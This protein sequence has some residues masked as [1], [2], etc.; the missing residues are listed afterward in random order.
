MNT[1]YLSLGA[2]LGNREQTLTQAIR[3]LEQQIGTLLRCSSF[4]YS[5]PWGFQSEHTFCNICASFLTDLTPDQL[6]TETQAIEKQLGRTEK[7]TRPTNTQSSACLPTY[8]DRTIDIDLLQ[9]FDSN[10]QELIVQTSSLTLPHP[11]MNQR[12][13]VRIPLQEIIQAPP[14]KTTQTIHSKN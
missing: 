5:E 13:F 3:M 7:T 6:L 8:H 10:H 14:L 1:V 2:N 11:L 4:F 9:Y 12:D